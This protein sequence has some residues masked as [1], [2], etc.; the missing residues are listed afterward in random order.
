M[1]KWLS[2]IIT[3]LVLLALTSLVG[4][5]V[6]S[7]IDG[8][9]NP[10]RL[11]AEVQ[12]MPW[13]PRPEELNQ[14]NLEP[15]VLSKDDID[16]LVRTLEFRSS[17]ISDFGLARMIIENGGSHKVTNVNIRV[18][19]RFS[20]PAIVFLDAERNVHVLGETTRVRLPDMG[21]GDR[22]EA[23][24]WGSFNKYNS[25]EI[26]QTYSSEGQFRMSYEWPEIR[27]FEYR[28]G[29]GIFLDEYA[30]TI[31]VVIC[32]LLILMLLVVIS[33]YSDYHKGLFVSKSLYREERRKFKENPK[34]FEIN[35]ESATKAWGMFQGRLKEN[36]L[37]K[38]K[39]PTNEVSNDAKS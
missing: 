39:D 2:N 24:F 27:D 8:L 28:T 33:V 13:V 19:S 5:L 11:N 10:S 25:D 22:I 35:Y 15:F 32:V 23:Y 17:A 34:K 38:E 37:G 12:L 9:A 36:P 16:Q 20:D 30:W 18:D 1:G 4:A 29:I 7:P 14:E 3:A 21:P 6:K 31:F 26:F